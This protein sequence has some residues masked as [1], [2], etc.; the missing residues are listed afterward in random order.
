MGGTGNNCIFPTNEW[1]YACDEST[2]SRQTPRRC[3]TRK[4]PTHNRALCL[5][6][7]LEEEVNSKGSFGNVHEALQY[8]C[9]VMPHVKFPQSDMGSHESPFDPLF[10]SHHAMLDYAWYMS[11]DCNNGGKSSFQ[12]FYGN[13]FQTTMPGFGSDKLISRVSAD[14]TPERAWDITNYAVYQAVSLDE[15]TVGFHACNNAGLLETSHKWSKVKEIAGK[16]TAAVK[17]TTSSIVAKIKE[18]G[19]NSAVLNTD[20]KK[21]IMVAVKTVCD[22]SGSDASKI[23]A[24]K[25][26]ECSLDSKPDVTREEQKIFFIPDDCKVSICTPTD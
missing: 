8:G 19:F 21:K 10:W 25:D 12:N 16:I 5:P 14:H 11:Q 3:L 18:W 23:K 6:A 15:V 2:C 22:G 7:T 9:H 26:F 17:K 20:E 1:N 13:R 24:L 4:T